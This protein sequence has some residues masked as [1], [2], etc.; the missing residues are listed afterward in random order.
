MTQF[1]TEVLRL[2]VGAD[3]LVVGQRAAFGH[4]RGLCRLES[5][6]DVR[7]RLTRA[8][9]N[10]GALETLR[11]FW[12]RLHFDTRQMTHMTNRELIDAIA[13]ATVRGPLAAY[14]VPDASV[15]HVLGS[16]AETVAPQ[17]PLRRAG[18]SVIGGAR[19]AV[20]AAVSS[21]TQAAPA[22]P[23]PGADASFAVTATSGVGA[24]HPAQGGE[25]KPGPLQLA[26]M[27][28]EARVVEVLRRAPR[29]M[30]PTLREESVKLFAPGPLAAAAQVLAIWTAAHVIA[31]GFIIEAILLADG[32][33]T[34]SSAGMEAADKLD[35][36]LELVRRARDERELDEAAVLLAESI[37]LIGI[38]A[39][40]AMIWR[41]AN[42][43]TSAN[44][45]RGLR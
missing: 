13:L 36:T 8:M 17:R 16:A 12:A 6:D 44:K 35:Q 42:R 1:A 2:S 34:S 14:L 4:G 3:T 15:K 25:V 11:S 9:S 43:F 7:Q 39:F 30:P 23:A 38:P 33:T 28:I 19:A 24:V 22:A 5:E 21:A 20:A 32:L 18:A 31:A 37:G 45:S 29:R 10:P 40:A 26:L 27:P 41:G